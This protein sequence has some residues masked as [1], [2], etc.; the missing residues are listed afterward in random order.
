[1][2]WGEHCGATRGGPAL[3]SGCW[4]Q[5]ENEAP[6]VGIRW[7]LAVVL[8]R[9]PPC[10]WAPAPCKEGPPGAPCPFPPFCPEVGE[11]N[12]EARYQP[13]AS[14]P[15]GQGSWD[16]GSHQLTKPWPCR[17]WAQA[18]PAGPCWGVT[19]LLGF[20]A[21]WPYKAAYGTSWRSRALPASPCGNQIWPGPQDGGGAC[22]SLGP[23]GGG[24]R[25]APGLDTG[26]L[27][28]MA[29]C[30][31]RAPPYPC[32]PHIN[33][34]WRRKVARGG[35]WGGP[36]VKQDNTGRRRTVGAGHRR[37]PCSVPGEG[38]QG[39]CPFWG[40]GRTR[41]PTNTH[42]DPRPGAGVQGAASSLLELGVPRPPHCWWV[43]RWGECKNGQN[44]VRA[45]ARV[46][47]GAP[48]SLQ[49][50]CSR[51]M[52][53]SVPRGLLGGLSACARQV[54]SQG[55]GFLH[56]RLQ[57]RPSCVQ[58]PWRVPES[59]VSGTHPAGRGR[60]RSG[61]SQSAAPSS[62]GQVT[63]STPG[64]PQPRAPAPRGGLAPQAQ[65][66]HRGQKLCSAGRGTCQ[67]LP[68]E[69]S[70]QRTTRAR[71]C[72]MVLSWPLC[73]TDRGT[74]PHHWL[75]GRASGQP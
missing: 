55:P 10:G 42:W 1:M 60:G 24:H 18:L 50:L 25:P 40:A 71:A 32:R 51:V 54:A 52:G 58:S 43:C 30:C 38:R 44:G 29:S 2:S 7:H 21:S 72:P 62:S 46:L 69:A 15:R 75:P 28:A 35:L 63:S 20:A 22:W 57:W 47:L 59:P 16:V 65:G 36:K 34:V 73:P 19:F 5:A 13:V 26:S 41:S 14:G 45:L 48:P 8:G 68:A 39:C 27:G 49:A 31:A 11:G 53:S 74:S 9:S 66:G 23:A 37:G 17:G 12:C 70:P 56:C 67:D 4:A 3:S 64:E 6:C 61:V 33:L